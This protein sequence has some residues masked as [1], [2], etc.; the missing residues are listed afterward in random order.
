MSETKIIKDIRQLADAKDI[1]DKKTEKLTSALYL[2]TNFL[3]DNDPI[4][5]KLREKALD[6]LLLI[7]HPKSSS[8]AEM[9][10]I[11]DQALSDINDLLK[12]IDVAFNDRHASPM[13]FSLLRQEYLWLQELIKNQSLGIASLLEPSPPSLPLRSFTS[14][15][16]S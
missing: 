1:K 15:T 4:K 13:N 10:T 11:G 3:S 14:S 8:S 9:P 12:L 2:V 6:L 7:S 16:T 5:W